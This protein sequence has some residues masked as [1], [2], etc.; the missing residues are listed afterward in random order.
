MAWSV[1][2]ANWFRSKKP[3][4][5]P[6]L[7]D[8]AQPSRIQLVNYIRVLMIL[9]N[10]PLKQLGEE[11]KKIP[12]RYVFWAAG[13]LIWAYMTYVICAYLLRVIFH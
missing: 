3:E 10:I 9:R 12:W 4:P 13:L 5:S 1:N 8:L 7:P 11:L 6:T 2:P